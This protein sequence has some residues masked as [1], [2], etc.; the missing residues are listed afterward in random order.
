MKKVL[1]ILLVCF[2]VSF[3]I[4]AQDKAIGLKLGTSTLI[5]G[6]MAMSDANRIEANLGLGWGF[7]SVGLSG[8]YE[9]TNPLDKLGADFSWFYGGGVDLSIGS[10]YL[11]LGVGA[12]VGLEYNLESV[13]NIPL[14]LTLDATPTLNIIGRSRFGS[15]VCIG[16]RYK[17]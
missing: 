15:D 17:F 5:S 7:S 12:I 1:A 6:Q 4:H 10:G 2:T 3:A 16:I 14:Q 8:Y 13:T 11:N 9:W